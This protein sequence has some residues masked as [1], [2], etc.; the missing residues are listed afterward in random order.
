MD[1]NQLF[2]YVQS[3]YGLK[4]QPVVP[5][6]T[7]LYV[8]MSPVDGSY[9]AMLSRLKADG[10]NTAAILDLKCGD[11]AATIRDLPGFTNPVRVKSNNWVGAILENNRNDSAIKKALDY[12][13]KLAM[14]GDSVNPAQSQYL[15]IP[16][17]KSEQEYHA[18]TIKPRLHPP[19]IKSAI[20]PTQIKKMQEM[21]DYSILPSQGKAKNFYQQ[22]KFMADYEDDYAKFFAFKRFYPTY[23]DM[24][25]GQLR[26]YFAWRS[27]VR[28]GK[29][30]KTSTSYAYVYLYELLN[31][32][33]IGCQTGYEKL[34]E[35]KEKYVEKFDLSIK[36]YLDDWLKDYVVFYKIDRVKEQFAREIALDENYIILRQPEKTTAEKFAQV[37]AKKSSYWCNSKLRKQNQA[38]FDRVL[39][40]AWQEVLNAKKYGIAYYSSYVAQAKTI[41][42]PIFASSVFYNRCHENF[43]VVIDPAR[44][45][46]FYQGQWLIYCDQAVKRQSINL[47]NFAHEVDRLIRIK[48]KIGRP[49]KPRFV[50]R[51]VL[52]AIAA[53]IE[54]Y[55]KELHQE[56]LDQVKIDFDNLASIRKEASKTRDSLLTEE[57]K[58]LEKV[59][60]QPN[61]VKTETNSFD[62]EY[63]LSNDEMFLLLALLQ[64]KPWQKEIR[65][66]QLLPSVLADAINE[67]MFDEFGDAVIE[68]NEQDQPQIVA[69]Y[70]DDL[71]E[72]FLKE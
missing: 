57:E 48:F 5:G 30:E 29:Y 63:D 34:L 28:Q 27:K 32:I 53:G 12:A 3:K 2:K 66:K 25:L 11:F 17:E 14:N 70:E 41:K 9:F 50:D 54:I 65:Q 51:A 47:N 36:P 55:Q 56:K 1:S 26:S 38:L 71:K 4:F 61:E 44:K 20:I 8:L 49:I 23:H 19:K 42:Q 43:E 60:V 35:F 7:N 59:E 37:F 18:Q 45:Y 16:G 62:N 58:E 46:R 72:I 67:K 21:Y 68:F 40:H 22:G 33:G 6:S 39:Y 52:R 10:Q 24:T 64:K 69:D 13:F 15:Y 31:N